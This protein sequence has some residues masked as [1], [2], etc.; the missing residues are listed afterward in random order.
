M[1]LLSMVTRALNAGDFPIFN[2]AD[3]FVVLG[4]LVLL[5]LS[6]LDDRQP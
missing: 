3:T 4:T 5:L 6:L 1:P 2:L